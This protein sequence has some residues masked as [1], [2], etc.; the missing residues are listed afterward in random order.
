M[1]QRLTS[2][3]HSADALVSGGQA[4]ICQSYHSGHAH[5]LCG[6]VQNQAV[7]RRTCHRQHD[8]RGL[9]LTTHNMKCKRNI[10]T[11]VN[12]WLLIA[13]WEC[14]C[15][16]ITSLTNGWCDEQKYPFNISSYLS[17][18][19]WV[20]CAWRE[21]CWAIFLAASLDTMADVMNK[22]IPSLC[23]FISQKPMVC[24]WHEYDSS[25]WIFLAASWDPN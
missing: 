10:N 21:S 16:C 17:K 6:R 20:V 12:N 1:F 18:S 5:D 4:V 14:P 2:F 19:L 24:S 15:T 13:A 9:W 3:H 23:S 25:C 8:L 11:N 7:H 22:N